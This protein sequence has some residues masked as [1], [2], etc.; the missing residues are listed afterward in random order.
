MDNQRNLLEVQRGV[1]EFAGF[2]CLKRITQDNTTPQRM[3]WLWEK[4]QECDYAFDDFTRGRV[5]YFVHEFALEENE[6]YE[7]A[8]SGMVVMSNIVA[9]GGARLHYLVW[10][11]EL[12]L[13]TRKGPA[14]DAFDYLFFKRQVH[15]V[16]GMIPSNNQYAIR[17]ATAVGMRFEGE[18]REDFLYKGRYY[19]MHIY[20]ILDREYSGPEGRRRRLL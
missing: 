2:R 10:D 12:N 16:V 5:D 1:G 20:G 7:V 13:T 15:H 3:K 6:F 17:F 11:R 14:L 9:Q 19:N 8:D 4:M 18:I